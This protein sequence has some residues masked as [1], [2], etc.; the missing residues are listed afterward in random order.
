MEKSVLENQADFGIGFT[1]DH[2]DLLEMT[3]LYEEEFYLIS[4]QRNEEQMFTVFTV[5]DSPLILF[6]NRQQDAE[7]YLILTRSSKFD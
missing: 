7:K 4:N 3:K 6:P 2:N 5:L 1:F